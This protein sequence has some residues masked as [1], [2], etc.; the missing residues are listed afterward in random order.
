MNDSIDSMDDSNTV[1][2]DETIL[3]RI[4]EELESVRSEL[5]S[6]RKEVVRMKSSI[7]LLHNSYLGLRDRVSFAERNLDAVTPIP[8]D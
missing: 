5:N 8:S 2:E 1:T 4:L 6:I 7:D 3:V